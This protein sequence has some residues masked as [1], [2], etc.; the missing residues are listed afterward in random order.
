MLDG[1]LLTMAG[2]WS[3]RLGLILWGIAF[4]AGAVAVFF[5][6][7]RHLQRL[8]EINKGLEARFRELVEMKGDLPERE[9]KEE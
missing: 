8:R 9:S 7:R 4:G 3:G 2:V 6:W 5:F 1:A